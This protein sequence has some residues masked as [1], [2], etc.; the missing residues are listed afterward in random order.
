MVAQFLF[1]L[2]NIEMNQQW[3]VAGLPL[4]SCRRLNTRTRPCS[5]LTY[6]R[7]TWDQYLKTMEMV[8]KASDDLESVQYPALA[9]ASQFLCESVY[10]HSSVPPSSGGKIFV[11]SFFMMETRDESE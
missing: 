6:K 8:T 11:R 2:T 5:S 1:M 4:G 7:H 3:T 10:S 9:Q